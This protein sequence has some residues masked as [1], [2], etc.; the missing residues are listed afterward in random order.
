MKTLRWFAPLCALVLAS[1]LAPAMAN[2]LAA[3]H[4]PVAPLVRDSGLPAHWDRKGVFVEILVRSYQDSDGDGIGD[5]NGVTRRLDHL[6]AL[7]VTGIWLMPVFRSQDHDHGYAPVDYREIEPEYGTLADF[8]RLVAEAHRRGIGIILDYVINHSGSAHPLFESA[9]S[10]PQSPYR[11]WYVFTETE[12]KGWTTYGGD[13]WRKLDKRWYYAAFDLIMPDFNLRNPAVVDFHLDNVRFWLNRGVDG[14]RF[15]AV[16]LLYENSAIAWDNQPENHVL[17]KRIQ[18]LLAQYGKRYMV[19]EAASDPAA[20]AAPDSCGST[21]AF[22]LQKYIIKSVH[23]GRVMPDLLYTL[24]SLPVADM[25]TVLSSHDW[26][27][28]ARPYTQ[29]RGELRD[30]KL[31]AATFLTLPGRPFLYYGEEIGLGPSEG[32]DYVDQSI[33]GPMSWSAA[34]HAGFTTAAAPYRPSVANWRTHNVAQAEADPDSLL[35]WYRALIALRKAEPALQS[36]DFVP[37]GE[38]D[39]PV[40]AFTRSLG[41]E[42]VLVL[43]NYARRPVAWSWPQGVDPAR[44]AVRFPQQ[45]SVAGGATLTLPAQGVMVFK[46]QPAQ[47]AA[48]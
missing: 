6:Q 24:R 3:L 28:G 1:T 46:A 11:D 42:K 45:A 25:A 27:A 30:Y 29:F 33:R 20:F 8:D 43:I 2:P 48:R 18:D 12:P 41:D 14:L 26:Y 7:G 34:P 19:C 22:G 35:H 5:L 9:V 10:D 13:P 39:E 38:G 21:F 37:L 15:D 31:A 4:A 32:V 36:G 16:G 44:W 17:M 40:L 23:L 47:V